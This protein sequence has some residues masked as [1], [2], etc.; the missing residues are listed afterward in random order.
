M[1]DVKTEVGSQ[2][3]LSVIRLLSL[4]SVVDFR[5]SFFS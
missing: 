2:I 4:F 3:P 5:P 1:G